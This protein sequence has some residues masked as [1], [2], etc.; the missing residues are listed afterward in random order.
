VKIR[1]IDADGLAELFTR[2]FVLTGLEQ[3][4]GE[5]LADV[6]ASGREIGGLAEGGDGRVVV[7]RSQRIEGMS[8]RVICR[9]FGRIRGR[10]R[11]LRSGHDGKQT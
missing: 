1:G 5:I 4:V 10:T 9:I 6:G 11:R 2:G 8:E 3:G 7:V